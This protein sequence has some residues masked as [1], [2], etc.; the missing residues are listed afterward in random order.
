VPVCF[1]DWKV[2]ADILK[3]NIAFIVRVKEPWD[4]GRKAIQIL[5]KY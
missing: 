3:D 1:V 4:E 5:A 2:F